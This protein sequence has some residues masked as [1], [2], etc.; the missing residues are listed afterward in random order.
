MN[1]ELLEGR[2]VADGPSLDRLQGWYDRKE[3]W[4]KSS[5][6]KRPNIHLRR[7]SRMRR[8]LRPTPTSP[9]I[10]RGFNITIALAYVPNTPTIVI[11]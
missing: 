7:R 8:T 9:L 11:Q 3:R 4:W 6:K 2:E 10:R 5:I 1:S